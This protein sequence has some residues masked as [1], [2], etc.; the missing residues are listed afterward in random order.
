MGLDRAAAEAPP[1]SYPRGEQWEMILDAIELLEEHAIEG[2]YST[3]GALASSSGSEA[4][5]A[6][7]TGDSA[8][9]FRDGRIYRLDVQV[10]VYSA[11]AAF[12]TI[13]RITVQIRQAVNSTTA[14]VLGAALFETQGTSGSGATTKLFQ[15]FVKNSTGA[16]LT[17]VHL[18]LTVT[19]STGAA[20][21][22]IYGDGGFPARIVAYDVGAVADL[23]N[24]AA[25]A[26]AL[27]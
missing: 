10:A 24:L 23:P 26:A 21:N 2:S 17:G 19:R 18:G 1:G 4:A 9:T 7:W 20:A 11:A 16:D 27:T 14:T 15:S 22:T 3:A 8:F 6:S 5:L 13:E 25:S 12:A